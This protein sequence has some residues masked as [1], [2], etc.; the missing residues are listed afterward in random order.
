MIPTDKTLRQKTLF[1][2]NNTRKGTNKYNKF[3]Q[4]TDKTVQKYLGK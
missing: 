4:N 1:R 2:Q 3:R